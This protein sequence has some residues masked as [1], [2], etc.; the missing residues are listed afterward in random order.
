MTITAKMICDSVSPER[1][2][3]KTIQARYPKFIHS[4]L[5]T[6][7][8]FSR[9]ASSSRAIPVE[10]LI[11][12][13]IDDT[14]MPL[15]WFSNKPGM[16]GGEEI[17]GPDRNFL[18]AEWLDGRD[19]AIKKARRMLAIKA[20]KQHINRVLE[21]FSHINVLITATS[22]ANFSALR[23]HPDAQPEIRALAQAIHAASQQSK[24]NLLQ[25]GQWHLPYVTD[26]DWVLLS[27]EAGEITKDHLNLMIKLS[28]ARCARVSYLTQ[29]GAKPAIPDD[30]KLFERLVGS[31]PLHASP[32][33]HQATPD[34]MTKGHEGPYGEWRVER[35]DHP[36]MHGNF[37]G[38]QQFRKM[39][40]GEY[41]ADKP[42][43]RQVTA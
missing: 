34:T 26:E 14:A 13:V 4:E 36:Q 9:N 18:I 3:I 25:P 42:F 10:R 2:R 5:M 12:D 15:K 29:E 33:E 22:W 43:F 41:L 17:T 27:G 23:D 28:V 11:Q 35:W 37:T 20:H 21:P 19:Y 6:H 24:P 7:R 38:W 8:V 40:P 39:L 30:V 16:Q 32:A 1:I 31:V